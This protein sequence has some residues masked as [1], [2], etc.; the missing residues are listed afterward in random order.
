[1]RDHTC[2][3]FI[4][5]IIIILMFK[6]LAFLEVSIKIN[7]QIITIFLTDKVI[8]LYPYTAQNEDELSFEKD[9]I[10]SVTGRDEASWWRGEKNGVTGLFPSNYVGPLTGKLLFY[11]Y[12]V[13]EYR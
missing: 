4:P 5:V 9:D 2:I 11:E 1:M 7:P 10:I 8:A 3:Y 6:I 12:Y 13:Y